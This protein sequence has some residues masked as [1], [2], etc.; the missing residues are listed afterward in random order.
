MNGTT[1]CTICMDPICNNNYSKLACN[2]Y[3][4]LSCVFTQYT[5]K[6]ECPICRKPI[7]KNK[8]QFKKKHFCNN[9]LPPTPP[10]SP[11][12]YQ[13]IPTSPPPNYNSLHT[14]DNLVNNLI[15]QVNNLS[16]KL[17]ALELQQ[18]LNNSK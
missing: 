10:P 12:P 4:C 9:E 18:K 8:I 16:D 2:H 15:E 11:S 3:F 6:N 1:I 17:T 14:T 5:Y 13:M 7:L